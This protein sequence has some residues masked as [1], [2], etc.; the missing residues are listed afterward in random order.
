M[1]GQAYARWPAV[2]PLLLGKVYNHNFLFWYFF[3]L[4]NFCIVTQYTI[5]NK[6]KTVVSILSVQIKIRFH[7]CTRFNKR[8]ETRSHT[9]IFQ[10]YIFPM[11]KYFFSLFYFAYE[12]CKMMTSSSFYKILLVLLEFS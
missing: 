1:Y 4:L 2:W 11:R 8:F 3:S 9:T 5:S 12:F 10:R 6:E 7:S